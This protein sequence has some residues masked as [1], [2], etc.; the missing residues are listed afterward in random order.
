MSDALNLSMFRAYDIRTPSADLTPELAERLAHA[1]AVYFRDVLK[2][3][4]VTLAHDARSTGPKYLT[5]AAEVYRRAGLDVVWLPGVTS[6]SAFYYAAMRRPE[7][8][9]VMV[10]ASHNP[11]GDTGRK[12][13]GPNVAPI[14]RAIGPD[15]GLDSIQA[16][17]EAG[18]SSAAS[19][20]G[21]IT[22]EDYIDDYVAFSMDLA[23]VEP[24]SLKG[25]RFFHDYL[26]GAAGR[27]MVLAFTKAGADLHPL[28][29]AADG[30]FPLGD[31]NP[32]KQA[33]IREGI[34][35]MTAG[36][37]LA[38]MFFDGDG[39]R[40]DVYRGEG[41]YLSSSFVYAAILPEIRKRFP[42]DGL[43]VFADLKCNPLAIVE[44]ARCGLSVDV[45]RNGHSQIKQSLI[46]DP[47]RIG[48]VEES[49]HFYEAFSP[50]GRGR[51]CTENTLYL[52]LL[53]ARVWSEDPA[54]FDR[55]F[56]IQKT[57]AREREWGYKFPTDDQRQDALD[58]VRGHFEAVGARAMSRMK[59]GMDL[60]ATLLRRGLSFDVGSGTVL[61]ADWLQVC[62]RV[63]QSENGLARW[64]VVA[65]VP[66]LA[67]Q[68]RREIA[69]VVA[70]H[71]AGAEYQG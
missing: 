3:T 38:G 13:L 27:E 6:T 32:V 70:R 66:E 24:G 12:I 15:G 46:D 47:K 5:I 29:F 69:E 52:A 54:R 58:A 11:A 20:T 1:E 4:G 62:Q 39:D 49:A 45:I 64:E 22:A 44:M 60:E 48:C 61:P 68:A 41:S 2:T 50:D 25:A 23:G 43:G 8:A 30:A 10:G 21:R 65:A 14:A 51:Y 55:M 18:K 36:G 34:E 26:F 53:I 19:S 16:I 28:H 56:E 35:A 71:G 17:Y 67:A 37:F 9:A 57:T 33:V 42:G 40:L 7:L 63:S 59:N 31:P